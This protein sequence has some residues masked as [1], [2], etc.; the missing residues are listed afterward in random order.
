MVKGTQLF[1]QFDAVDIAAPFPLIDNGN[2]SFGST[3]PT[4]P[5]LTPYAKVN[6]YTQLDNPVTVVANRR[7]KRAYLTAIQAAIV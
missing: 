7:W 4:G 2:T 5:K 1:N 6:R 3:Q